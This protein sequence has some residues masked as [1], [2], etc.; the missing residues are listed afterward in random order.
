MMRNTHLL[1]QFMQENGIEFDVPFTMEIKDGDKLE[2]KNLVLRSIGY[3]GTDI[4]VIDTNINKRILDVEP[5]I[6]MLLFSDNVKI[7]KKPWKPKE[8]ELYWYVRFD[9]NNNSIVTTNRWSQHSFD[10][11]KYIIGNCFKTKEEAEE[12]IDDVFKILKGE[13]LVK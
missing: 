11:T 4:D 3:G 7:V 12:H 1:E 13:P 8:G 6:F 10:F 2:T 9:A 5:I